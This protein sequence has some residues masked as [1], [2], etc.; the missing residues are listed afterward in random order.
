MMTD[1]IVLLRNLDHVPY[2]TEGVGRLLLRPRY[3]EGTF[4]VRELQIAIG[5]VELRVFEERQ[6]RAVKVQRGLPIIIGAWLDIDK[7]PGLRESLGL[8]GIVT[9]RGGL[10]S[11]LP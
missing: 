4:S 6:I 7:T 8:P 10:I 11:P 9:N 1:R 3:G 2:Y 5:P